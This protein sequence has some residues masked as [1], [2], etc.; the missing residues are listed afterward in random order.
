LK[1]PG[2]AELLPWSWIENSVLIPGEQFMSGQSSLS[3]DQRAVAVAL[4]D[5]GWAEQAV[6][7][8]LAASVSAVKPL[9]D[10]WRVR[11]EGAL[12][13]EPT[14]RS[15]TFEFKRDIVHRFL[16]GETKIVLA[17]EFDLSSPKLIETW[18]RQ[19]R[20]EGADGL[21]PRPKGRPRKPDSEP[22]AAESELEKL[23][24]EVARLRV[25]NAYLG[26]LRALMEQ[27]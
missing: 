4:F 24:R 21:R 20:N 2:P 10:R 15:F 9:Y 12:V 18:A 27:E 19:Y 14:K 23:R 26:K 7:T 13:V 5:A 25:E 1:G 8:R 11:G 22:A 3:E 16:A 6:A 17:C